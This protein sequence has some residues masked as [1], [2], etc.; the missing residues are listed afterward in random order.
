[1][2]RQASFDVPAFEQKILDAILRSPVEHSRREIFDRCGFDNENKALLSCFDRYLK[3][4]AVELLVDKRGDRKHRTYIAKNPPIPTKPAPSEVKP[5][6]AS[7]TQGSPKP[8]QSQPRSSRLTSASEKLVRAKPPVPTFM[9]HEI[10][11]GSEVIDALS[12]LSDASGAEKMVA[13]GVDKREPEKKR[14]LGRLSISPGYEH[15]VPLRE[16]ILAAGDVVYDFDISQILKSVYATSDNDNIRGF[17]PFRDFF[18]NHTVVVHDSVLTC[19]PLFFLDIPPRAIFETRL[20]VRMLQHKA[21]VFGDDSF[22]ASVLHFLRQIPYP[23]KTAMI[24]QVLPLLHALRADYPTE[25]AD[26][27]SYCAMLPSLV[28]LQH[29]GLAF[30]GEIPAYEIDGRGEILMTPDLSLLTEEEKQ[31]CS[32][33]NGNT[34]L[35]VRFSSKPN[36]CDLLPALRGADLFPLV[37]LNDEMLFQADNQIPEKT[38]L[39]LMRTLAPVIGSDMKIHLRRGYQWSAHNWRWQTVSRTLVDGWNDTWWDTWFNLSKSN[40]QSVL[41]S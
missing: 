32:Y 40:V 18:A 31:L 15:P 28:Y 13:V 25:L 21:G 23:K 22:K 8:S 19:S 7:E 35:T 38:A 34:L 3:N 33:T 20:A 39:R 6:S 4:P 17:A 36:L 29:K 16:I 5:P 24:A 41:N 10:S 11:E 2:P 37:V 12:A 14:V 9:V 1:M 30:Q 27:E 26:F